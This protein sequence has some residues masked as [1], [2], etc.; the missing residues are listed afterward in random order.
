MKKISLFIYFATLGLL[1]V[2]SC[3]SD[4]NKNKPESTNIDTLL[5]KYPD[6]VPILL[7]HGTYYYEKLR[8]D[9]A[10]PSATKAFRLDSNNLDVRMLFAEVLNN[11]PKRSLEN[12][13]TAQRHFDYI[14]K[15]KP[16]NTKALV[17]LASTFS[18][19]QDFERSFQYINEALRIDPKF[20]D[21]YVLKGTNY[22][23][24]DNM[25]LAKSS[26]ETATQQDPEFFEAY[27][28]LGDL[29]D[30]EKNPICIQYFTTASQLQPEDV[31]VLYK[32]A[33]AYQ[34]YDR[35]EDAL[36]LYRVMYQKDPTFA[37]SLFQQGYIKHIYMN[38]IDSAMIYYNQALVIEPK[39]VEA[40]HNLGM[41]YEVKSNV[42]KALKA[43]SQALK[44]NP[45]FEKS[46]EAAEKLR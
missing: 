9:K 43:Y 45:D 37:M 34:Q 20:R 18:L 36:S 1:S 24:M 6:S 42:P 38:E 13:L 3:K 30:S 25:K 44:Y 27:I 31:G 4:A 11:D 14:L 41:C 7:R 19:M 12:V 35:L 22:L 23:Q 8:F 39:F 40:W 26:Y 5:L 15:K 29:Y 32:L 17:G 28:A 46:R 10:L 33:Y 21:A 16:K 2:M